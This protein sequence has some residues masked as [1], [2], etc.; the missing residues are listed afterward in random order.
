MKMNVILVVSTFFTGIVAGLFFAWAVSVMNGL[1]KLP[2]K[3]FILAMQS[4]NREIQNPVFFLF[5]FGTLL[6][7]PVCAYMSYYSQPG[8]GFWLVTAATVLY[9]MVIIITMAGNVPLNNMLDQF[10]LSTATPAEVEALRQKFEGSWNR[11]N[12]MRTLCNMLSFLL[13]V[14]AAIKK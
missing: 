4:L 12:I 3:E 13:L 14:I 10:T 2:H 11:L 1:G 8:I 9:L 7:L 6:L 5:L